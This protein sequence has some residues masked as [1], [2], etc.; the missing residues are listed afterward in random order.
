MKIL[1]R[2]FSVFVVCA[3][4]MSLTGG[5]YAGAFSDVSDSHQ[6]EDAI[7]SLVS[8]GLLAGYEDGT[9]RPDNTITRAEFAAVMTRALGM[10]AYISNIDV[11]D[12]FTDM[13]NEDGSNHWSSGYV[14]FA[15]DKEII[16]GMGD[17][18]FAPDSPVTYEQAM[19]MVVCTLGYGES[20]VENGGWPQGYLSV[21]TEIGL[22]K[23][24]V[25]SPS[26]SPA[27]R[28][29][30][31]Q[32][33]F[34]ALN[35]DLVEKN[36]TGTSVSGGK[37]LL[38][39]KLKVNEFKNYMITNVDGETTINSSAS[40]IKK[41]EIL[42]EQGE[43]QL[44]VS[45]GSVAKSAD[46]K[47]SIGYYISGYYKT[48]DDENVL[49]SLDVSASKNMELTISS[50]NIELYD[51][52]H[53]EYW[54][55]KDTDRNTKKASF[56]DEIQLIY[57]G[58]VYD[59]QS[60][61]DT[62]E[63]DLS[64]WLDPESDDFICGSIRLLDSDGDAYYDAVFV[65][66][67]EVY[68]VKS[69]PTTTDTIAANNYVVYD[70]YNSGKS[71]RL[72]PLDEAVTINITNAKTGAAI[73]VEALK[74]MN[75]LSVARS[76][77][78]T[79]FNCYVASSNTITGTITKM[80]DKQHLYTISNN[81]YELTD[82][83]ETVVDS[84]KVTLEV[85]T[86]GT[87]YLD[88]M[89]RIAAVKV[90]AEQTG[91][92]GYITIGALTGTTSDTATVK[93]ISLTGTPSTPTKTNLASKVKINGKTYSDPASALDAL[94][95]S[96]S[97]ISANDDGDAKSS[98]YSQPV[99]YIKS[100]SGEITSIT[101]VQADR[102]GNIQIGTNTDSGVL[103]M[104]A[105]MTELLYNGSGNF[106][107]TVFANSSTKVLIVP[108]DRS[109]D[110]EYKRYTGYSN[111]KSSGTY[112]VE[113]YDINA[114][115]IASVLMVYG[116]DTSSPITSDT[117]V[118]I[119]KNITT[120]TNSISE[121][122][123]YYVEAYEE[124]VLKSYETEDDSDVFAQM[125]VGDIVRFGFN[126]DNHIN[127]V[128]IEADLDDL[129][130][131]SKHDSTIYNGDYKF[132]TVVG[133][134]ATKSDELIMV[135]PEK[136]VYT[137]ES[138]DEDGNVTPAGYSLDDTAKEG[139]PKTSGTKIYRIIV[140]GGET[141]VEATTWDSI[142]SY[143]DVENNTASV[144]FAHAYNNNLKLVVIYITE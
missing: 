121:D 16:S 64:K 21:G 106:A 60:S 105:P 108:N 31:A 2:L 5:A 86:N 78:D 53:L 72:D 142:T 54:T 34:N 51:D 98:Q 22:T 90:T 110:S 91:N 127:D 137:E 84:G 107:N 19:K 122:I 47:A 131:E 93:L 89:G 29:I 120:G 77:D 102:D 10:E 55:N 111:F 12:V 35:V 56:S 133:T 49:I 141:T 87:Y 144:V 85:G 132:K 58:L 33:V 114:S 8:L 117:K 128:Q 95:N 113:A 66:D 100:S 83:F 18:T 24:A 17:G 67:Y 88:H 123:C 75:I 71:I 99:R 130:Y 20:A 134:V 38:K 28:G 32:L 118:S 139:Y 42:L 59:Y 3:M 115:G 135:A 76:L 62:E 81:E 61:A 73:Q 103:L 1:K 25:L 13:K 129:T 70:Y 112:Y 41:G 92:Y 40:G 124:G 14:K 27:T 138:E 119:I 101:T 65:E 4:L 26:S 97:L 15:Y 52:F 45:Y 136:V 94:E 11:S 6:Y 44:V 74:A 57:N 46:L 82:E 143:A 125:K 109:A 116:A 69:A 50:D 30:V 43:K 140:K 36:A 104:G 96:A 23:N 37:T 126:G 7:S 79:M 68:V 80:S 63:N 39:D 9:F 48:N